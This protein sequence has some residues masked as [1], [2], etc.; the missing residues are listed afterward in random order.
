MR[1]DSPVER[2]CLSTR[3]RFLRTFCRRAGFSLPLWRGGG[4]LKPA[5]Q[6][7]P[8]NRG[9]SGSLGNRLRPQNGTLTRQSASMN[10][11]VSAAFL[12]SARTLGKLGDEFLE[13]ERA[14]IFVADGVRRS[15]NRGSKGSVHWRNSI[16]VADWLTFTPDR[17]EGQLVRRVDGMDS[18][19]GVGKRSAGGTGRVD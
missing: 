7:M 13:P 10:L 6:E 15:Y 3:P 11:N 18:V 12:C 14:R 1:G 19:R 2:G 4:R 8:G 5:L 16:K 9:R 17:H